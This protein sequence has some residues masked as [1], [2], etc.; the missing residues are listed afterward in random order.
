MVSASLVLIHWGHF[1]P[2]RLGTA[3]IFSHTST[4]DSWTRICQVRH[5]EALRFLAPNGLIG[6][7]QVGSPPQRWPWG[8]KSSVL[9]GLLF[10][11]LLPGTGM[12]ETG[13]VEATRP[14]VDWW[15]LWLELTIFVNVRD[16][17]LYKNTYIHTYIINYNHI[18]AIHHYIITI[19]C[20]YHT[21][22]ASTWIFWRFRGIA[23]A[24][25]KPW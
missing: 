2:G 17:Y 19:H 1:S 16:L 13:R 20:M 5:G 10:E 8:A 24:P 25:T 6:S 11:S 7:D 12:S 9:T 15:V 4:L 14:Y 21:R 18:Y 3:I 23:K 22:L